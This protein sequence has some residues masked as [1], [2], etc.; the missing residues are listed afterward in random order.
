MSS[1]LSLAV[2]SDRTMLSDANITQK[3]PQAFLAGTP[4]P[5]TPSPCSSC[6]GVLWYIPILLFD[7]FTYVQI[8]DDFERFPTSF[9]SISRDLV[10]PSCPSLQS[11]VLSSFSHLHLFE[12]YS[13]VSLMAVP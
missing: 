1:L 12:S 4:K 3:L 6:V 8:I 5:L 2:P 9:S 7:P 10:S 13:S 11:M